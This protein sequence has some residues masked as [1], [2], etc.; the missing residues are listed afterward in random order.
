MAKR[1]NRQPGNRKSGSGK[2]WHAP[3]ESRQD[4]AAT[5]VDNENRTIVGITRNVLLTQLQRD[6][7]KIQRS[8]D[9]LCRLDL[10]ELSPVVA[11]ILA[12]CM[13]ALGS[14]DRMNKTCSQLILNAMNSLFAAVELLR[15]GYR[16]QP[17]IIERTIIE[18]VSTV[19]HLIQSPQDLSLL[20]AGNFKSSK[21]I[22]S[23]KKIFPPF[24]DLYG[25]FSALFTHIGQLHAS[26]IPLAE[27]RGRDEALE[28]NLSNLRIVV[29]LLRVSTE[30]A[31]YDL[32]DVPRYW[33]RLS[34]GTY[35][36]SP[37]EEE[38]MWMTQFLR[39]PELPQ[40]RG[41]SSPPG[42]PNENAHC[43]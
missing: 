43:S 10:E 13:A 30:F 9:R 35:E 20:D 32:V 25:H 21:T 42:V 12:L 3:A 11:Q 41:T 38:K 1:R 29:F 22:S 24:G 15:S 33:K 5:Y 23:A 7:P 4:L 27:Y 18:T 2:R 17:G 37:S 39:S 16:L 28:L 8:F 34:A 40:E 31:F 14:S 36:F 6:S 19:L 26:L